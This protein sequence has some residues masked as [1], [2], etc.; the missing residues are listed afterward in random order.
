MWTSLLSCLFGSQGESGTSVEADELRQNEFLYIYLDP[1]LQ[2]LQHLATKFLA[3]LNSVNVPSQRA[4]LDYSRRKCTYVLV[5]LICIVSGILSNS[6]VHAFPNQ[7]KVDYWSPIINLRNEDGTAYVAPI[8]GH[9]L[10]DGRILFFG[11]SSSPIP[12]VEII[13][14]DY[15]GIMSTGSVSAASHPSEVLLEDQFP[16]LDANSLLV[17]DWNVQDGLYCGGHTFTNDGKLFTGGGTRIYN[18]WRSCPW[19]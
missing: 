5:S 15:I 1:L 16:I 19:E 7:S 4:P 11:F 8:H 18:K 10:P 12:D 6:V 3:G 17:D 2:P 14:F 9:V 13:E